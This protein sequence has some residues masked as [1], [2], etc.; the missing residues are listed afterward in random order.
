MEDSEN[1]DNSVELLINYLVWQALKAFAH[2]VI[3]EDGQV[4]RRTELFVDKVGKGTVSCHK[5]FLVAL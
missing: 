2:L 3:C 5:K 1:F 4:G